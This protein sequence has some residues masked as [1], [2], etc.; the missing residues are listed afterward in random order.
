M[1]GDVP[2]VP[3]RVVSAAATAVAASGP[4]PPEYCSIRCDGSAALC[5]LLRRRHSCGMLWGAGCGQCQEQRR[6][7]GSVAGAA[8]VPGACQAVP[9]RPRERDVADTCGAVARQ[10]GDGGDAA[11][12]HGPHVVPRRQHLRQLRCH[13]VRRAVRRPHGRLHPGATPP[14]DWIMERW[15]P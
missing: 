8:L 5:L 4:A 3:A 12:E 15:Q 11:S 14:P 9:A 2:P 1:R 7:R 10:R 13:L 6:S